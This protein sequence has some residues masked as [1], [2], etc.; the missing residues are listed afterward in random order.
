[1]HGKPQ[2]PIRLDPR[3]RWPDHKTLFV[4]GCGGRL[5]VRP[6]PAD[7]RAAW[8]HLE[9]TQPEGWNFPAPKPP[10]DAWSPGHWLK[11]QHQSIGTEHGCARG[12]LA[13]RRTEVTTG[14]PALGCLRTVDDKKPASHR[15]S[16]R[17]AD[18]ND[19]PED[20]RAS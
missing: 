10:I 1:M 5:F 19:Q 18:T 8:C 13:I 11:T 4:H 6:A 9:T 14:Y 2:P 12:S 3:Q 20:P 7:C 15:A 17:A 16:H